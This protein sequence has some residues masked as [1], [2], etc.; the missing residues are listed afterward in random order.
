MT[1]GLYPR[2]VLRPVGDTG[3]LVEYGDSIAPDINRKV[4]AM[5]YAIGREPPTGVKEV[6]PTYRSLLIIYDPLRTDVSQLQAEVESLERSLDELKIPPPRTIEIPVTYGGDFGPDIDFVARRANLS[7]DDVIRIHSSTIYQVYMIGFTPGFP[8][9]GGLSKKLHA[10]RLDTP[11]A[12]V[13]A[14]SV[15]IA[16]DQTGIYCVESPGGWRLIGRTPLR[17]FDPTKKNPLPYRAGDF[18]RFLPIFPE[19]YR[20][21]ADREGP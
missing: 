5:A 21:I 13:P 17:L 6:I 11:R 20:R 19:D 1:G 9:L 10:P 4:R 3:L 12:V 14:G 16:N 7:T 15:G 8:Y 2:A 18:I